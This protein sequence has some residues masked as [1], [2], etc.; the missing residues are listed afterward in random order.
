VGTEFTPEH[1]VM[2]A[3]FLANVGERPTLF[4]HVTTAAISSGNSLLRLATFLSTSFCRCAGQRGSFAKYAFCV[5]ESLAR[6]S[7]L[8]SRRTRGSWARFADI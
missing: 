6:C 3:D 4:L 1:A 5:A 7:A 2:D 8:I